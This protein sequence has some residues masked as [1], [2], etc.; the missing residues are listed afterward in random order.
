M[1]AT[2]HRFKRYS[3][4]GHGQRRRCAQLSQKGTPAEIG[5]KLGLWLLMAIFLSLANKLLCLFAFH[6]ITPGAHGLAR[7]D[8]V[9]RRRRASSYRTQ[10]FPLRPTDSSS[11]SMGNNRKKALPQ[12]GKHRS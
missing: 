12:F 4:G 11:E 8:F 1:V 6:V 3:A 7:W 9:C 10:D 2:H 5:R